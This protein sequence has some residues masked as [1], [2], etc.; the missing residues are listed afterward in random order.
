ML[1]FPKTN[2]TRHR[3]IVQRSPVRTSAVFYIL[4]F[5]FGEVARWRRKCKQHQCGVPPTSYS[6][7]STERLHRTIDRSVE[8]EIK[9]KRGVTYEN[10]NITHMRTCVSLVLHQARHRATLPSKKRIPTPAMICLP[11]REPGW[12]ARDWFSAYSPVAPNAP[13]PITRHERQSAGGTRC[14][15]ED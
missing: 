11:T 8:L 1:D 4:F 12:C 7:K 2:G 9:Q 6:L 13:V 15:G 14:G 5:D 10:R 3:S